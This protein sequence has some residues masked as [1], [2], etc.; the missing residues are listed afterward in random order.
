MASCGKGNAERNRKEMRPRELLM[1]GAVKKVLP[2]LS[3]KSIIKKTA[4][5]RRSAGGE[6]WAVH[7]NRGEKIFRIS[8]YFKWTVLL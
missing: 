8:R 3:L 5:R 1:M 7:P 6:P 4:T 2:D